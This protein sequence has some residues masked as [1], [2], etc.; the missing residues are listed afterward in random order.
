MRAGVK[1]EKKNQTLRTNQSFKEKRFT[2]GNGNKKTDPRFRIFCRGRK[3]TKA[4]RRK[5]NGT[6][7]DLLRDEGSRRALR[8]NILLLEH[9]T[10]N[11]K[12]KA[13]QGTR[14]RREK[15]AP[16]RRD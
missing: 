4:K 8:L 5:N 6:G 12:K 9:P 3:K 10:I 15:D 7:Q 16:N 1:R 14:L 13:E 2:R 11:K